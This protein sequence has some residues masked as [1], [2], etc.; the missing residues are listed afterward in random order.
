MSAL[1]LVLYRLARKKGIDYNI[2]W[3]SEINWTMVF[4]VFSELMQSTQN[5]FRDIDRHVSPDVWSEYEVL[6][7]NSVRER[8]ILRK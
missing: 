3:V 2:P 8:L 5:L 7:P 6:T 1:Q 4:L